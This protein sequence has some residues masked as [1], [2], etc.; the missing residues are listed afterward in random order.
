VRAPRNTFMRTVK[1]TKAALQ[2]NHIKLA[3]ESN[4][5]TALS[6]ALASLWGARKSLSKGERDDSENNEWGRL[7]LMN[8]REW[9][10]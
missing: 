4:N 1:A 7:K 6:T 2:C 3:S 8:N 10:N 9:E 5:R